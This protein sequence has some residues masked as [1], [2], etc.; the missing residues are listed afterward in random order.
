MLKQKDKRLRRVP[1]EASGNDVGKFPACLN[2]A[3]TNMRLTFSKIENKARDPRWMVMAQGRH[4][5]RG[6]VS[7]NK[8]I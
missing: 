4:E 7:W 2:E 1:W 6:R 5:G 8:S 3:L